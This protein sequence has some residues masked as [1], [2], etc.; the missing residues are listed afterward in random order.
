MLEQQPIR[1][2]DDWRWESSE[3]SDDHLLQ[4]ARAGDG[5]AFAA[6]SGRYC[7]LVRK[8]IYRILGHREDTEDV[9]QDTLL[10]AFNHLDQFQGSSRFST[11]LT[12]IGI[13]SAFMLLRKRKIRVET[14]YDRGGDESPGWE[15][16]DFPDPAPDPEH[17]YAKQQKHE[18]LRGAVRR[19][20][21]KFRH[22]VDH[23]HGQERSL[24]ET[25]EALG[26]SMPAAKSRLL[27]ARITLRRS[28]KKANL[29]IAHVS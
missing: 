19:L 26:I 1:A 15:V 13:N 18:L 21:G 9:L 3:E 25:A 7:G 20:P 14:S 28:L 6:L 4:A 27:R 24:Q 22:I 23:Y 29:S 11:W 8:K 10:K 12:K 17:L 16:W 2:F 5:Q